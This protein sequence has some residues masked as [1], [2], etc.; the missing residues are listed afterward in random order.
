MHCLSPGEELF[1]VLSEAWRV[2]KL[3]R[4]FVAAVS[5]G[6]TG[7][8]VQKSFWTQNTPPLLVSAAYKTP[9]LFSTGW[10][11]GLPIKDWDL[12]GIE[13]PDLLWFVLRKSIMD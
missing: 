4:Y 13:K 1:H 9:E 3:G 11:Q 2:L 7:Q 8:P 6:F 10:S 5:E 12:V